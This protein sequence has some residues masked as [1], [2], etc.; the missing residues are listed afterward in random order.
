MRILFLILFL[1]V[2]CFPQYGNWKKYD[3][4]PEY[5]EELFSI[6]GLK[7]LFDPGRQ[8]ITNASQT[9]LVDH[10]SLQYGPELITNGTF[11]NFY[12]TIGTE[13]GHWIFNWE[14]RQN[15]S[16]DSLHEDLSGN[17]Y[18]FAELDGWTNH[19]ELVDSIESAEESDPNYNATNS[20][21]LPFDGTDQAF[22][23]DWLDCQGLDDPT[24]FT[25]M[26]WFKTDSDGYHF[27]VSKHGPSTGYS[28]ELFGSDSRAILARVDD[29]TDDFILEYGTD[30]FSD[31]QWH[32][33]AWVHDD[34][35]E[36]NCK[37]YIDA[38]S[39][40]TI[41]REG[42]LSL[43]GSIDALTADFVVGARYLG[44]SYYEG[45]IAEVKIFFSTLTLTQIR[46]DMGLSNDWAYAA[47]EFINYG[48]NFVQGHDAVS[49]DGGIKQT[50]LTLADGSLYEFNM[51]IGKS[52]TNADTKSIIQINPTV[53]TTIYP[54]TGFADLSE[55]GALTSI[56]LY[57]DGLGNTVLNNVAQ[58]EGTD[59]NLTDNVSIREVVN[60]SAPSAVATDYAIKDGQQDG[61]LA[62]SLED[63]QPNHPHA[64]IFNGTDQAINYGNTQGVTTGGMLFFS[65]IYP[66]DAT[67]F[68][69][70]N[71]EAG[72][73]EYRFMIGAGD[74]IILRIIDDDQ[75]NV[76]IGRT[77]ETNV[78]ERQ[79]SFYAA[80]WDGSFASSGIKIYLNGVRVDDA[81][82]ENGTLDGV[83]QE[84]VDLSFGNDNGANFADGIIGISGIAR[85]DGL[86]GAP[87]VIP[88]NIENIILEIY[89]LTK[90]K[91]VDN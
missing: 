66:I 90:K 1:I 43:V 62:G 5:G 70:F 55:S 16:D 87:A 40:S 12:G 38:D 85:F 91:Y 58:H 7:L 86:N 27:L 49:A 65:W 72:S 48:N 57:N 21:A 4:N 69:I 53:S 56:L 30:N 45:L 10:P 19:A 67:S 59:W 51:D 3:K 11:D 14:Y 39:G 81:D 17:G 15:V 54:R 64:W 60:V 26:A 24:D 20:Y 33:I 44:L 9:K 61:T 22:R 23:I 63:D 77:D 73:D 6:P 84:S 25:I 36:A 74:D 37:I 32:H 13:E 52:G 50:G 83:E 42:D 80:T 47:E 71:K 2:N 34:D 29:G 46:A 76:Y 35:S 31:N 28:I 79:W 82:S 89:D 78:V 68:P 8:M 18:D 88:P 75:D 41:N